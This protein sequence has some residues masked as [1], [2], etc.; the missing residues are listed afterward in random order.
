M[1][2]FNESAYCQRF[3]THNLINI[4]STIYADIEDYTTSEHSAR[5]NDRPHTQTHARTHNH[6]ACFYSLL[7]QRLFLANYL[8]RC[9]C[10]KRHVQY[11]CD[12]YF[13]CCQQI[14]T[15]RILFITHTD[16]HTRTHTLARTMRI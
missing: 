12:S 2:L 16:T 13:V 14:D 6:R 10:F 7:I 5:V 8:T 1:I 9:Q 11:F 3:L 4:L 15:S